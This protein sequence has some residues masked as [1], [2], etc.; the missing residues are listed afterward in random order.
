MIKELSTHL[1]IP[2]KELINTKHSKYIQF[3]GDADK[4]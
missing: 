4:V 3:Y 1:N 2:L